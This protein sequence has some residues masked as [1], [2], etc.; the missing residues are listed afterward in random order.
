MSSSKVTSSQRKSRRDDD[1][2]NFLSPPNSPKIWSCDLLV[3]KKA[4]PKCESS[5][6]TRRLATECGSLREE[7]DA[8]LS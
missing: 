7:K 6:C 1:F 5:C 2:E 8:K 4:S 3:V